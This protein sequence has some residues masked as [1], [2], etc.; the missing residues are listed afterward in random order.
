MTSSFMNNPQGNIPVFTTKMNASQH[1]L[2]TT[3]NSEI[4]INHGPYD[5]G[6]VK[7]ISI[8]P[9]LLNEYYSPCDLSAVCSS[10]EHTPTEQ[11]KTL[12]SKT[13]AW[14]LNKRS[15]PVKPIMVKS[16]SFS[17]HSKT[18]CRPHVR[19]INFQNVG[20]LAEEEQ[21]TPN[22]SIP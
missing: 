1:F 12:Q 10:F 16:Q 14:F 6:N 13:N 18:S 7:L 5:T 2:S 3:I 19:T 21:E 15:T 22:T 8:R 11:T 20:T 17:F 4:P 9:L